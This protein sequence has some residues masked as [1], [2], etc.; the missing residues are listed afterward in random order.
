MGEFEFKQVV[1]I[2]FLLAMSLT[3]YVNKNIH[4]VLAMS[5]MGEHFRS[6]LMN[7][8]SLINCMT[9]NQSNRRMQ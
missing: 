3:G 6:N 1:D 4:I 7:F 2:F 5:K 8:P 9:S